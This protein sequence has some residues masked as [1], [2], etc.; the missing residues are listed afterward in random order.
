MLGEAHH[1]RSQLIGEANEH[2]G[3]G[4]GVLREKLGTV[5]NVVL[6]CLVVHELH[7][8]ESSLHESASSAVKT[9]V[10]VRVLEH[11]VNEAVNTHDAGGEV[12]NGCMGRI[13]RP[14]QTERGL[15]LESERLNHRIDE[16]VNLVL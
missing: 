4:A 16:F 1:V 2:G 7:F 3:Q 9:E 10:H 11:F 5:R 8:R 13:I 14:S 6:V 12:H 15:K